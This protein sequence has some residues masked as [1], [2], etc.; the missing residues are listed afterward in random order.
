MSDLDTKVA[1]LEVRMVE[2]EKRV[3]FIE[4]KVETVFE[5]ISAAL[6]GI[7]EEL[8]QFR[9]VNVSLDNKINNINITGHNIWKTLTIVGSIIAFIATIVIQFI[10]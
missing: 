10:K 8:V 9:L 3:D 2:I 7:K 4:N 1:I 6:D 5:K